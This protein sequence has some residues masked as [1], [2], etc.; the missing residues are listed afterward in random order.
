LVGGRHRPRC[1]CLSGGGSGTFLCHRRT[2]RARGEG[3]LPALSGP[4]GVPRVCTRDTT[5]ARN[6]GRPQSG[7][8]ITSGSQAPTRPGRLIRWF[9][10]FDT[11]GWGYGRADDQKVGLLRL[12]KTLMAGAVGAALA[13]LLDPVS[14]RS[15]RARLA[16]QAAARMKDGAEEATRRARYEM[17]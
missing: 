11:L 9:R 16:D 15:R 2:A 6:L 3:C 10:W 5:A 14:G 12:L 8:T 1:G 7:R 17:G 13:Y 4:V